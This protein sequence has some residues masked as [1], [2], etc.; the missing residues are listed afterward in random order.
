LEWGFDLPNQD[1]WP[2]NQIL[3]MVLFCTVRRVQL[4]PH[5][6]KMP[7]LTRGTRKSEHSGKTFCDLMCWLSFIFFFGYNPGWPSWDHMVSWPTREIQAD[8]LIF[9]KIWYPTSENTGFSSSA[10]SSRLAAV[11]VH[12]H[13]YIYI[14][15][16]I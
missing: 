9:G 14:R 11:I 12:T 1:S 13:R 4:E 6:S 8:G 7:R 3:W 5:L 10:L 15:V 16:P 2:S